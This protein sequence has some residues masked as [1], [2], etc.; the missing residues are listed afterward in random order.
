M[1]SLESRTEVT[2]R[3]NRS[4]VVAVVTAP[5][6]CSSTLQVRVHVRASVFGDLRHQQESEPED[7]GRVVTEVSG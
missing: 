7:L 6:L 5:L 1:E 2:R 3:S 4:R